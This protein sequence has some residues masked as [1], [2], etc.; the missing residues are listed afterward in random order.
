MAKHSPVDPK[1]LVS[2]GDVPKFDNNAVF[3]KMDDVHGLID[4]GYEEYEHEQSLVDDEDAERSYEDWVRSQSPKPEIEAIAEEIRMEVERGHL[5]ADERGAVDTKTPEQRARALRVLDSLALILPA[6][7][8]TEELGDYIGDINRRAAAGQSCW[9]I[10]L[11]MLAAMFWTG[12]NAVGYFLK[13][14]W[15]RKAA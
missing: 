10:Y 13:E 4:H 14:I 2:H 1:A 12:V 6:R 9:K 7:I 15:T 5:I 11:R 3:G 8:A